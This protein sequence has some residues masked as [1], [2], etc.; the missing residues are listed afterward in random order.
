MGGDGRSGVNYQPG[1]IDIISQYQSVWAGF[2]ERGRNDGLLTDEP[3][4]PAGAEG[5]LITPSVPAMGDLGEHGACRCW[6]RVCMV[7]TMPTG[8]W[9]PEAYP[10]GASGGVQ[11]AGGDCGG[12]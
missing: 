5:D 6:G 2:I 12:V 11:L 10:V 3:L 8:F 4:G 1:I 9:R 7:E